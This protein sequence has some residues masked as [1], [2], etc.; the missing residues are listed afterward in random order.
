MLSVAAVGCGGGPATPG[1]NNKNQSY[2]GDFVTIDLTNQY[3]ITVDHPG[4]GWKQTYNVAQQKRW[5]EIDD[6]AE[7]EIYIVGMALNPDQF[8]VDK[9][10]KWTILEQQEINVDGLARPILFTH[11]YK[12]DEAGFE[13]GALQLY[14]TRSYK[15][16]QP[17]YYII[18]LRNYDYQY[19]ADYQDIFDEI[20]ASLIIHFE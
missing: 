14:F 15:A 5:Q 6:E 16:P 1:G 19:D 13:I 10:G 20:I 12:E 17:W 11:A 4:K 7:F 3:G 9:F 8:R 18:T 2:T